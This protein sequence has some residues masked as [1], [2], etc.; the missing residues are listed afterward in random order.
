MSGISTHVLDTSRGRPAGGVLVRL[1][2]EEAPGRWQQVGSGRTDQ[3]GRCGDLLAGG[4]KLVAG[5][6]RLTFDTQSYF[7]AQKVQGLYPAVQVIF[8][9]RDGDAHF[10][11]PLLLSANGY[12]TYRGS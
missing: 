10:H 7:A 2:R 12:T 11:I 8:L 3:N 4:E 1:D 9:V 6:Y 5:S